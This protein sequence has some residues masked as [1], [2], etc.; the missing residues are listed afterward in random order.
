MVGGKMERRELFISRCIR[1]GGQQLV[2]LVE[3]SQRLEV[4]LKGE[5]VQNH[6][7]FLVILVA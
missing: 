7:A 4:L 3:S 6:E 5:I 1:P 2:L